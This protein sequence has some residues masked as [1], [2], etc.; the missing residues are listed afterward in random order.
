MDDRT[1]ALRDIA[2]QLGR[3]PR[4]IPKDV[5]P[6]LATLAGRISR[7]AAHEYAQ[8]LIHDHLDEEAG[9]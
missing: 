1:R 6:E 3:D 8:R 5:L 4:R 2:D 9:Q 7:L